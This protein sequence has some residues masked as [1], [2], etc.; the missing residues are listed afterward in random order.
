MVYIKNITVISQAAKE[1]EVTLCD[2]TYEV[3]CFSQ[4]FDTDTDIG[5]IHV[6]ECIGAVT[7]VNEAPS[8]ERIGN[9]FEHTVTGTVLEN[10]NIG[11]GGLRF[12]GVLLP[13]DVS[14]GDCVRFT[15]LRLDLW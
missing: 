2:G 3:V 11:V 8:V 6:F 7:V 9:G 12:D 13:G 15:A 5:T 4:P 14:V 10:G 1:C